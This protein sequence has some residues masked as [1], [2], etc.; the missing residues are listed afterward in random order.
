MRI[1][2][3]F[4]TAAL[5]LFFV[6]IMTAPSTADIISTK[7]RSHNRNTILFSEFEYS[8]T[9]YVSVKVSSVGIS[10]IPFTSNLSQ[11]DPSRIGFFLL[12]DELS[13][14]YRQEFKRNPDLCVLDINFISVLFTFRDLSPPPESSFN[15]SY[16][17]IYPG[18]YSLYFVNCNDLS[19]LTM[20][21]RSELYNTGF[22]ISISVKNQQCVNLMHLQMGLLLVT[23]LL[24]FMWA[25]AVQHDLKV[26]DIICG[27]VVFLHTFCSAVSFKMAKDT[28]TFVRSY[29]SLKEVTSRHDVFPFLLFVYIIFTRGLNVVLQTTALQETCTLV[30]SMVMLYMYRPFPL[31]D[32]DQ[33]CVGFIDHTGA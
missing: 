15:K 5:L 23:N 24:Y 2:G 16:H 28:S 21:V 26:T 6:L 32:E 12:S 19:L 18:V 13:Y 29:S 7:I 10:S 14:R 30:F 22:L 20:D 11:P 25:V 4:I 8:H 33:K 1:L 27:V 31:G 9:G 3:K 17:V